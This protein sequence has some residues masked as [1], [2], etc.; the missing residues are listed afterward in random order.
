MKT[1]GSNT[2]NKDTWGDGP[3]QDE[4]DEKQWSDKETGMPCLIV[5]NH[6]GAL[7]G[8]VGVDKSHPLYE[9]HYRDAKNKE[10][11]WIDVHGGLTFSDRLNITPKGVLGDMWWFGFD[12]A[13]ASDFSPAY[14]AR[15]KGMFVDGS[16]K[17][18]YWVE[19]ECASIAKQLFQGKANEEVSD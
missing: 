3:W 11:K 6:G 14:Y 1:E 12:C 16:Y 13:H 2:F 7:C 4:P 5:R 18:I 17:N 9:T 8:Y 10:D 15:Y 19:D